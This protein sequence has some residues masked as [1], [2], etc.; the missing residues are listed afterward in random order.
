MQIWSMMK[1]TLMNIS[2]AI[3]ICFL[4]K[5]LFSN[6][7]IKNHANTSKKRQILD[8]HQTKKTAFKFSKNN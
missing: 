7:F 3:N 5:Y 6:Y 4:F 2:K 1:R 8:Q